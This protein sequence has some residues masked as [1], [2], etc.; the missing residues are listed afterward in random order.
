MVT[1][2]VTALALFVL[3]TPQAPV[4]AVDPPTGALQFEIAVVNGP[5][6]P[7]GSVD[8]HLSPDNA[9]FVLNYQAHLARV[10]PDLPSTSA[11]KNCQVAVNLVAPPGYT[12]AIS[13]ADYAGTASVA[14]GATAIV[15]ANYY[16][17]GMS[18]TAFTG[19]EFP[20]PFDGVW[21][22][23]VTAPPDAMQ[24]Y[25]CGEPRMININTQLRARVG[26]SGPSATSWISFGGIDGG[27]STRYH[28]LWVACPGR[29]A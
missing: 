4:S 1:A 27:V 29:R 13:G 5:G 8:G 21:S 17:V 25:P 11:R 9:T 23:S 22:W 12:Y 3:L 6:C 14:A 28:L 7:K 10:G 26:T 19:K 2:P 15:N 20:G 16:S 24:Y 18:P